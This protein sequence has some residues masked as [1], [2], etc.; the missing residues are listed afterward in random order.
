MG[1]ATNVPTSLW[2]L[3]QEG[4]STPVI[5]GSWP[6]SATGWRWKVSQVTK[7]CSKLALFGSYTIWNARHSFDW[8]SGGYLNPWRA[9]HHHFPISDNRSHQLMYKCNFHFLQMMLCHSIEGS[10]LD[11]K[12]T[13]IIPLMDTVVFDLQFIGSYFALINNLVHFFRRQIKA[14]SRFLWPKLG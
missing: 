5:R 6:S 10:T 12:L 9:N 3:E 11:E 1:T 14:K 7:N 4:W 2:R 8:S 13:K